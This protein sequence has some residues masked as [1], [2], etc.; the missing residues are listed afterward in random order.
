MCLSDTASAVV[1][2]SGGKVLSNQFQITTKNL[3][4]TK[5]GTILVDENCKTSIDGLYAGGDIVTGE[6]TVISAMGAGR[7]A[8]RAIHQCLMKQEIGIS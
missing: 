2:I 6:A 3:E 8:A 7:K 1:V 4:A 5:W